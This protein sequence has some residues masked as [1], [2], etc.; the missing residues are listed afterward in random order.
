MKTLILYASATGT[1]EK[2]ALKLSELI[3]GSETVD[4]HKSIPDPNGYDRIIIGGSIRAG[5][6]SKKLAEYV[7]NTLPV[8]LTKELGVFVC[9]GDESKANGYMVENFPGELIMKA[10]KCACFGGEYNIKN[11]HGIDKLIL[12]L[13]KKAA[14]SGLDK[15]HIDYDRVTEFAKLF[16]GE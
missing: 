8:L 1:S 10:K 11:A 13:I 9:C 4:I 6:I 7:D 15:I 14:G 5:K 12:R 16:G 2:C 3:P